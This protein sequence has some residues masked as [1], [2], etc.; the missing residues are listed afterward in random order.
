MSIIKT[1]EEFISAKS[2]DYSSTHS[3]SV[4]EEFTEPTNLL[5]FSIG[6]TAFVFG[7]I[8]YYLLLQREMK[9][10]T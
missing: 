9:K 7:C 4:Y 1:Y 3:K 10:Y 2:G 8:L 6:L 5:Q